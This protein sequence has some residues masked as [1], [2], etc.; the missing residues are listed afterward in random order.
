MSSCSQFSKRILRKG[1]DILLCRISQIILKYRD[2]TSVILEP[3]SL[4]MGG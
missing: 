1:F 3:I 2:R 4:E